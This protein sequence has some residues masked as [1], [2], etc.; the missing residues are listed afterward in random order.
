M[1][2]SPTFV[3]HFADGEVTRM[4]THCLPDNLD[5]TRGVR[6]ADLAVDGLLERVIRV[7]RRDPRMPVLTAEEWRFLFAD[8]AARSRDEFGDLIEGKGDIDDAAEAIAEELAKRT[9]KSKRKQ[10]AAGT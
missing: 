10:Q 4:S 1:T 9:A 6:D 5:F 8:A 3:A 2:S 7:L